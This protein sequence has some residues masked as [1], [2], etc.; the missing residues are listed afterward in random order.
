MK[1][2]MRR[3]MSWRMRS[4]VV[5]AIHWW[6]RWLIPRHTRMDRLMLLL[7]L[8]TPGITIIIIC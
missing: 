6:I 7:L 4:H 5:V 2:R 8:M 1:R 3:I